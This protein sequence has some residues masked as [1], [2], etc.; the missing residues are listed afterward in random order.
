MGTP[1]TME[2]GLSD[3]LGGV[4]NWALD[5]LPGE[6]PLTPPRPPPRPEVRPRPRPADELQ[7]PGAGY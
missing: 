1:L 2:A 5:R 6:F 4:F 7:E 3:E